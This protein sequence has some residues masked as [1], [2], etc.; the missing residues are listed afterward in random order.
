MNELKIFESWK[1]DQKTV[2]ED[3][4]ELVEITYN[5]P[6][7]TCVV[8]LSGVEDNC[9]EM[10]CRNNQ[11]VYKSLSIEGVAQ[12]IINNLVAFTPKILKVGHVYRHFKGGLYEIVEYG[13]LE[14]TEEAVIIYKDIFNKKIYV[15][16]EKEFFEFIA[17]EKK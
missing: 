12:L 2:K 11:D 6:C 16:P 3:Y 13:K 7:M 4:K 9:I 1:V 14:S 17:E 10:Q 15:R 8:R 5:F